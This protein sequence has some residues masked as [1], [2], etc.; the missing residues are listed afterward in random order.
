[1]DRTEFCESPDGPRRFLHVFSALNKGGAESLV[2]SIY[3]NINR[4]T[5]QFDFAVTSPGVENHFFYHEILALGGQVHEIR[6]WRVVGI[7]EY[8]R[9]WRVVITEGNYK[10]VH[11]HTSIESGWPL[12]FAWLNRVPKRIAHAHDSGVHEKNETGRKKIL[13][14]FFRIMTKMFST[15]RIYCSSEAAAYVFGK[16]AVEDQRSH[17]LPNAIQLSSFIEIDEERKKELC[18][19]LGVADASYVLGTVGNAREVKNHI[20]LVRAFHRFLSQDP[21]A[22]LLIVG[23]DAK[24]EDAKE[25]VFANGLQNSVLFTGV[26]TNISEILQIF[27]LFLLPSLAEGA[28]ISVIEAQAANVPCILSDT[29][30][31]AVD[32]GTG[33][34]KYISLDAPMECWADE[35]LKS[36]RMVRPKRADT[37]ALLRR[38]GYDVS[39]SA[40]MLLKMYGLN[41]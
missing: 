9:Q 8:F 24:D 12:F 39:T 5:A 2:M 35:M 16:H 34:V 41:R 22:K 11:A 37:I 21:Q 26:K 10:V 14:R 23:D 1:M 31:R 36:C 17:F 13:S 20:F 3:R 33:L 4:E 28:P 32:V 30:T 18:Q 6:S 38:E 19:E 7:T 29:I 15:D 25:Y 40:E 27:D